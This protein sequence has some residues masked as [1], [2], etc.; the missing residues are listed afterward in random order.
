MVVAM[1]RIILV[2]LLLGVFTARAQT[3]FSGTEYGISFGGCQYFGD[4]NTN[5]GFREIKPAAMA[6]V[7]LPM[8]PY[9]S[10]RGSVGYTSVGYDDKYSNNPYQLERNLNFKSNIV[11]G[12]IQAEFNFFHFATGEDDSRFTPYLTGGIGA[13]YYNPYTYY[14]G[15]KYYLRPQGTEGQF[16]G[17]SGNKYGDIAMCFPVGVGVKYWLRPGINLGAEISDRLTTTGYLDDVHDTYVG[18]DKFA[19]GPPGYPNPAYYLQ[20]R[21]LEVNTN[22]ALGT[23]GKQRG[24]ASSKDQYLVFVVNFSFQ[25]KVYRCPGYLKRGFMRF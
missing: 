10:L 4:L 22:S 7:R 9:I 3:F 18:A 20:D 11:E 25:L 23:A 1:R 17:Y 8:N 19:K 14:N 16:A 2:V 6:Y 13:F 5:Y 21:S 15:T 12:L 24:N